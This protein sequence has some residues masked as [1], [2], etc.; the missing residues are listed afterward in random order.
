MKHSL[1]VAGTSLG[2]LLLGSTV[3]SAAPV[4][5]Q[6]CSG[7]SC[8]NGGYQ[9]EDGVV[10][11]WADVESMVNT[12]GSSV[13]DWETSNGLD[14]S[15][16]AL[17]MDSDP[18][19]T[20]NFTITNTTG[21]TQ[22]YTMTTTLGITPV[23]PNGLMQGSI[24]FSLTDN[25]GGG[26]TLATSGASLY[27]GMIDGNVA[28][29]LWDSSTSFTAPF[30]TISDSTFFG[31]P[32]REIAP[33]SI[34]STIG[35]TIMFSLTAGD[36]TSITSNF[37]VVPVPLPAAIWLFGSGILGLLGVAKRKVA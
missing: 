3:V 35:I 26:A 10:V 8:W 23:I 1:L 24:G 30:A 21:S 15:G 28:R 12:N 14:V 37:D 16:W 25:N 20:N 27:Q 19:V 22:T 5:L 13:N 29:T 7:T 11:D 9:I 4:S 34:D 6:V 36:S 32:T 18:F 31:F 17:S 2:A 33:E